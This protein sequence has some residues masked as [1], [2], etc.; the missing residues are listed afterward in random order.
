M[1]VTAINSAITIT[2]GNVKASSLYGSQK[3]LD[4]F[5]R[6]FGNCVLPDSTEQKVTFEVKDV[7]WEPVKGDFDL[8]F[9]WG[10]IADGRAEPEN[11]RDSFE[12]F[13]D[14]LEKNGITKNKGIAFYFTD[15]CKNDPK[16]IFEK[17]PCW[18]TPC[19]LHL[20]D[21]DDKVDVKQNKDIKTLI[22]GIVI[23]KLKALPVKTQSAKPKTVTLIKKKSVATVPLTSEKLT[24]KEQ[25]DDQ[26]TTEPKPTK[27]KKIAIIL[28]K[29]EVIEKNLYEV[30]Q[31][32][33]ALTA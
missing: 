9:C 19:Y 16:D 20:P 27:N 18:I 29:I 4:K 8:F 10:G 1:T 3:A 33:L 13:K 32:L 24:P 21:G 28:K 23:N 31:D 25:V 17:L 22:Q 14:A 7:S 26:V 30:K 5:T 11:Q 15:K 6:L 2:L 12:K